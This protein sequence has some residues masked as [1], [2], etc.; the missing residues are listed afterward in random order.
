MKI[1]FL[2]LVFMGVSF[3]NVAQPYSVGESNC[4]NKIVVNEKF[5]DLYYPVKEICIANS[6]DTNRRG[7][8]SHHGG[9]CGCE[10]NRAKCCD[11]S[12]SPSCKCGD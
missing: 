3:A 9:V 1:F 6:T 2:A 8:C 10:G 4:R 5:G 7:C 11:G 12:L